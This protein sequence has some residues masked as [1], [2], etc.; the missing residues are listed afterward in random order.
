MNYNDQYKLIQ[1][2]RPNMY[3]IESDIKFFD[4]PLAK[5]SI[6][7]KNYIYKLEEFISKIIKEV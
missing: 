6:D 1:K 2:D 4:R 3:N 5:D 7:M